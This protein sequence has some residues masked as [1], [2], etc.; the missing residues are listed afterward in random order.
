MEQEPHYQPISELCSLIEFVDEMLIDDEGLAKNLSEAK[1]KPWTLD[2][3]TIDRVT[4]VYTERSEILHLFSEQALRWQSQCLPGSDY[5]QKIGS[6]VSKL[7]RGEELRIALLS[8]AQELRKG[9]INRIMEKDDLE[10]GLEALLRGH[11]GPPAN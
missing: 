4:K 8:S 10:L 9:T 11:F 6:L 5:T 7:A 2:D 3:Y 1:A